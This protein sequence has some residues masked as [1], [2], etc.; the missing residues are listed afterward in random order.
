[1][2]GVLNFVNVRQGAVAPHVTTNPLCSSSRGM[3]SES[4]PSCN[5]SRNFRCCARLSAC[6][7]PICLLGKRFMTSM[8]LQ[9]GCVVSIKTAAASITNGEGEREE[10]LLTVRAWVTMGSFICS[11]FS[12]GFVLGAAPCC[13]TDR[14]LRLWIGTSRPSSCECPGAFL[15]R[16][17]ADCVLDARVT[18]T[19]AKSNCR[20][21][22]REGEERILFGCMP[23]KKTSSLHPFCLL[24]GWHALRRGQVSL[25]LDL[26]NSANSP[27]FVPP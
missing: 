4:K 21:S 27:L 3:A 16:E 24:S 7:T 22:K 5:A 26:V 6:S 23:R 9:T 1:M 12:H 19:D 2:L 10:M 13:F 8:T 18:D 14:M 15:A 25:H 17:G 20:H 11:A